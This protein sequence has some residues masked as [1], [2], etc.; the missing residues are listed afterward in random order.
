L[1]RDC[2]EAAVGDALRESRFGEDTRGDDMFA[3]QLR[4]VDVEIRYC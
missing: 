1:L 2:W 4:Y 3:R